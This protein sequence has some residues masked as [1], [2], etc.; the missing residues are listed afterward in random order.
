[1]KSPGASGTEA[2]NAIDDQD[3]M[4]CPFGV[5]QRRSIARH[6]ATRRP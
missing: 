4:I 1:M 6:G 3:I 5:D 2:Q